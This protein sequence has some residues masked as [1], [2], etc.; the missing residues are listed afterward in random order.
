MR[1]RLMSKDSLPNELGL[2]LQRLAEVEFT[3]EDAAYPIE[4]AL[5]AGA[6]AGK[7]QH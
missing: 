6:T 4:A 7:K 2:D 1:K 5:M 3:S